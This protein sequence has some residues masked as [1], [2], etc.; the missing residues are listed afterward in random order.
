MSYGVKPPAMVRDITKNAKD[1]PNESG[2][3]Q[4]FPSGS[5]SEAKVLLIWKYAGSMRT[6][7]A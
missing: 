3:L 4:D 6:G 5:S 7:T 1:V 2:S